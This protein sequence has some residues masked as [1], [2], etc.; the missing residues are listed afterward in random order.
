MTILN[1]PFFRL[2]VTPVDTRETLEAQAQKTQD[3]RAY[4]SLMEPSSRLEAELSWLIDCRAPE[5]TLKIVQLGQSDIESALQY[6][7]PDV[8]PLS[9]FNLFKEPLLRYGATSPDFFAHGITTLFTYAEALD[10]ALLKERL[11]ELRAR[12]GIPALESKTQVSLALKRHCYTSAEDINDALKRMEVED[13]SALFAGLGD[14][15]TDAQKTT[16]LWLGLMD[17][18]EAITKKM[19]RGLLDDVECLR[20]SSNE[21][22]TADRLAKELTLVIGRWAVI[23]K[24]LIREAARN[25]DEHPLTVRFLRD[26]RGRVLSLSEKD[27]EVAL[28]LIHQIRAHFSDVKSMAQDFEADVVSL[29]ERLAAPNPTDEGERKAM[30]GPVEAFSESVEG[31]KAQRGVDAKTQTQ[32]QTQD[33]TRDEEDEEEE[34]FPFFPILW[35]VLIIAG[36][37]FQL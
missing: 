4:L 25:D 14:R 2:G 3:H 8:E 26:V 6:V 29:K 9:A 7:N 24:P 5:K 16:A 30:T 23:A 10:P 18:Y 36:L 21:E 35:V 37:A 31:D 34:H 17:G 28:R 19:L 11:N 27:P 15:L 33:A 32:T 13:L 20:T 22:T 1:N 12:A